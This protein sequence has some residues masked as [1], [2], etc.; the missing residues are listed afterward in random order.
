MNLMKDTAY[1]KSG[2]TALGIEL[3][4]TRIKAVLVTSDCRTISTG[5]YAWENKLENGV[6][7]YS[8]DEV[9]AGVQAC[10]GAIAADVQGK[11]HVPLRKIGAIGVSAMMHGYLPF[12]DKGNQLAAFRT[13]RNNITGQ[14]AAALTDTLAFNIPERWSVAHL[15]QAILNKEE[16]VDNI[17]FLTT[18]AGYVHWKL[19]GEKALGIGDASGMFPV[20]EATGSYNQKMLECFKNLDDVKKYS[21]DIEAILPKV[22]RA[23]EIAGKLT[24]AGAHLLDKTGE[25]EAGSLMAPPEGD[26]GTGMVSTNSV[27]K[28]TGNISVGTSAFSMNV[29]DEPLSKLHKDIDIV[30]T[31]DGAPVAMVHINN[32]S[33]DINAWVNIFGEFADYLGVQVNPDELYKL[34]FVHIAKAD[35]DAGGLVNYSYLSGENITRIEQGR[36]MFART[37]HSRFTLP[38]FMLSQMYA[39]FAPLKIGM[40]ILV[41]QEKVKMDVM[42]AQGGLF[43]TPIIAQQV[44]ANV[45]NMP[46]TVMETAGEGGPWGMAV[47][48]VYAAEQEKKPLADFLDETVFAHTES[49]TLMPEPL[50]VS[51]CQKFVEGYKKALPA[52]AQLGDLLDDYSGKE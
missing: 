16:H 8:L 35:P 33:S 39:A 2:E 18:L 29:L 10:Y 48:A 50:G 43:R 13:W 28:R 23:G 30:T 51:G 22:Y 32:C 37:P 46:I 44:L 6:W 45:L 49:R 19:C 27:R 7:T 41:E 12:D 17:A 1:I 25:L 42:V 21:W 15:Y 36:P 20:D 24:D 5:S 4:S 11:Y 34:L 31:P 26:A 47:L 3:G 52:E 38:N 40:D 9:W 14:A